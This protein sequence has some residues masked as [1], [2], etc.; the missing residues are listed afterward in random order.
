M[1]DESLFPPRWGNEGIPLGDLRFL[2][3]DD[4]A[5][6]VEGKYA[7]LSTKHRAYCY[8]VRYNQ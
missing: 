4:F 5:Q 6:N 3:D 2:I 7:E 1:R 8:D